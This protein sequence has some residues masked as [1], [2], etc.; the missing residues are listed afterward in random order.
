MCSREFPFLDL[1]RADI[2]DST[3][4]ADRL[5]LRQYTLGLAGGSMVLLDMGLVG[6]DQH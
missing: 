2:R 1:K 3:V 4:T 6:P 5:K